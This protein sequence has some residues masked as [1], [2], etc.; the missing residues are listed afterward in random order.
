MYSNDKE[1]GKVKQDVTNSTNEEQMEEKEEDNY[2]S[3]Y[4]NL[5]AESSLPLD[6]QN[7]SSLKLESMQN[8][9]YNFIL[10]YFSPGYTKGMCIEQGS[11][12]PS[13]GY[14]HVTP[15]Y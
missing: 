11:Q 14:H 1:E 7:S 13:V 9:I 10:G 4:L 2:E 15:G 6:T 3:F 12:S 5:T 8:Q